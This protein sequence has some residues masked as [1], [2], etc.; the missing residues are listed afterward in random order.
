MVDS[1]TVLYEIYV[2]AADGSWVLIAT[3][4]AHSE[5]EASEVMVMLN[6]VYAPSGS[7][8]YKVQI[9]TTT[10]TSQIIGVA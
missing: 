8:R 9:V 1:I 5:S 10:H 4:E 3:E 2:N 7:I 6:Q